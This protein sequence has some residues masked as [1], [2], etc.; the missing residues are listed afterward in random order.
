MTN[1]PEKEE[2]KDPIA[3]AIS[4]LKLRAIGP[5]L[6]GGRIAD[7]AIHPHKRNTWYLAVGSG[8][9]WKTTNA[10]ITWKPIFEDQGS[11]SLGC[12]TFD[13]TSPDIV[14]L[15]TGE[16]VSGRHVGWGD[17]V[18]RSRNGGASWERVG[19][20]KSEHI[21]KILVDPRDG[22]VVYVAA[23]GAL[24][25]AGGERGVYKTT[26]GGE[27]WTAVLEIDENT[28]VTD[29]AFDPSNPN[30]IYAAAYQRRR[31]VATFMGGGPKSGIY[32]ST[33]GGANWRRIT[34]GLPK[35]DMGKIGLAVTLADPSIVYA[36]I[37]AGEKEKGFYR[38]QD[39]G[40]SWEK[41]NE[42]I[43]G[44]TGP[45]Y[46]QVIEA[47]PTNPDLIYQ[48]DVFVHVTRDGGKTFKR[49]ENG[50]HKHSDNHALWIDPDDGQH[51]LLGCDAGLYESFDEGDS[52]RHFPNLPVSQFYRTAVDN[53]EPFYNILGGAQDLGTLFGPSRMLH[54][55]GVRNQDWYVPMGA[56]GYHVAFD[57]T[58]PDTMYLEWQVGNLYRYDRRSEEA[59]DIKPYAEP[60][61]PPERWNWDTPVIIS[62]HNHKRLYYASQRVWRSDD[63]G[64]S[65]MAV[66]P[67]LTR[68]IN[69]YEVELMGRVWSVDDLYD[70]GAMSNYS[71]ISNLSESSLVE[72]LLY[73]A[74]D[75]GLIQVSE[76]GGANWQQ[77]AP[78]P[79]VA[80]LAFIQCVRASQHDSNTVF[81]IAGVH[82]MG[83]YDPY[84]F[85][86]NDRGRSWRSIKGDLP[87]G[88]IL[89]AVEQDHQNAN[90]L[91][92]AAEYGLYA[93][94]NG[95]TNWYKLK[96]PTIAF[97]DLKLQRRDNDLVG[98]SFGRGFYVLDDYTPLREIADALDSEGHLF[99][100]RDAW[101]YIP[102]EPM[103][104][105][106]Q[107][108]LGSTSFKAE[109][110]P[111]GA[112]FTYHVKEDFASSKGAR[113]KSEKEL[114]KEGE[115]A[116]FPGWE[117]LQAE[118][119]E[120]EPQVLLLVR[121][122]AGEPIRWIKAETKA[123]LHRTSWNLRMTPPDPIK[124]TKDEFQSP[125]MS[126]PA[127]PLAAPG[128]YSVELCLV[129]AEGVQRISQIQ[130]FEVKA[131]P[132]VDSDVDLHEVV[133]FQ[134][135]TADLMRQMHGAK[136]EIGRSRH[137]LRALK[138]A[139]LETPRA[140]ESHF[141][142][143][144][145]LWAM[146][147]EF[148]ERMSGDTARQKLNEPTA[149]AMFDRL[150]R[151]AWLHWETRQLPTQ[152]QR[153]N[154][155]IAEADFAALKQ[156]LITFIETDLV[157][158]EA[159]LSALGA[160]WTHGRQL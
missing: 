118:A 89:W 49:L 78:L 142:R 68:N 11:Y 36:T 107:P 152:T 46:Y 57:P 121:D 62:P 95:G 55:E 56:D 155:E 131:V 69:R 4:S 31:S 145:E 43:S 100:V 105:P 39:K 108:T 82:K 30:T 159:E 32:K 40:E 9:L 17:G 70:T 112:V 35:G 96:T 119:V 97:R 74:T 2:T 29:I 37:E 85:E 48:M 8:N 41:R 147:A 137:R 75:D 14:W 98:A 33:D 157:G 127:G 24:W 144:N 86:S 81:A 3:K 63:R 114:A 158:L 115:S 110:P 61:E 58:D 92:L 1:P 50:K 154:V 47:S 120:A 103:Q 106:G 80:E 5:A 124:L 93:S 77:A 150:L 101:W 16:N 135:K 42:Y 13:P 34:Q 27:N 128:A 76:D 140:D 83:D 38:S 113:R 141:A 139:L 6:M 52:W 90:L 129:S 156:E 45:H 71:T 25:S 102:Y 7:I 125:W 122:V 94:P 15:G 21:G 133:A 79:G 10:G 20:E 136:R 53:S 111:F 151:V 130:V 19:L 64:D 28:G 109:N 117:T 22:N 60:G 160:P 26:D 123:G 87:D 88:T 132:T 66:S 72:G 65:W 84:I 143:A 146:L 59:T 116:T 134:Q 51:L 99:P 54:T 23:E 18:Y 104:A 138:A 67:D 44:G 12:V 91:F 149:P 148:N 73:V 153:R 126:P